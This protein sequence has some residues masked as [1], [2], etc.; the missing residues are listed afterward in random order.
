MILEKE[1]QQVV[2]YCRLMQARALTKGTGGNI[3]ILNRELALAAISPSG[4]EYADMTAADVV[5]VDLDGNVVDGSLIPSS[6]LGMHL[7]IYRAR[8]DLC[9]VVHTHS[10]FATTIACAHREL[11]AVHYL[12][13]YSGGDTVPCIP[14]FPFGS[15]EL[16]Q[17]AGDKYG[18]IPT[19][20]ALL[21]GNHG[22]ITA[23]ASIDY[24]FSSAE[25]IEFVC[26][27]YYRQLM[28]G[29]E[30]H[31]LSHEQMELVQHKFAA[32]GQK[33]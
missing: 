15:P 5:V 8:Q 9:A 19:L 18:E 28:M 22:L 30:L 27:L 29:G 24:A 12:I 2:D 13:G 21:L 26:E 20:T 17:A 25:E 33:K 1:R 7:A 23:G 10:T 6:E 4:V 31:L 32:Y 16:A 3:S 11:P 14:Y